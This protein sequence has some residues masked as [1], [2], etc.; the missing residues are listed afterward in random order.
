MLLYNLLKG[1]I[2]PGTFNL[3]GPAA[4]GKTTIAMAC[5][6]AIASRGKPCA[7]LD[8]SGGFSPKRFSHISLG[9]T[10]KDYSS[11][12]LYSKVSNPLAFDHALDVLIT[13]VAK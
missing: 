1:R 9:T 10:G 4:T 11:S 3:F 12:V 8:A 6:A 2:E 13:S 5:A 7:W